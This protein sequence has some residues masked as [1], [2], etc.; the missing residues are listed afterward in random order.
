MS[1][2]PILGILAGVDEGFLERARNMRDAAVVGVVATLLAGEQRVDGVMKV[3]APLPIEA[4]SVLIDGTHELGIVEITLAD[5]DDSATVSLARCVDS[6]RDFL[7]EVLRAE[8]EDPV[9][10]I[11]AETVAVILLY[12]VPCVVD[13]EAPHVVAVGIVVVESGSPGRPVLLGEVRPELAEVVAL[14]PDV[15][16]DDVEN[17]GEAG[18][19]RAL[20]EVLECLGSSVA[21]L[22]RV[23]TDPVVAPVS[24]AGEL[25]DGH[26]FDGGHTEVCELREVSRC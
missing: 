14:R 22:H 15:V 11:E 18:R 25:R 10:R 16:V 19:M 2:A 9:D 20:D 5:D 1:S 4:V 6:L 3:V 21:V 8:I 24:V 26:D 23:E 12:P 7:K 13:D 17:D